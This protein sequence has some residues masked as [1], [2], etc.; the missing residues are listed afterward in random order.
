MKESVGE[1]VDWL[2]YGVF[3]G[4]R[5]AGFDANE[6]EVWLVESWVCITIVFVKCEKLHMNGYET[7]TN[8]Q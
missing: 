7:V 1:R 6:S 2:E 4:V 5:A 8:L 3:D